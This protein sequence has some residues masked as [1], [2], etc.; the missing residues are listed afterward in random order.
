MLELANEIAEQVAKW[1]VEN[2]VECDGY[3]KK[4]SSFKAKGKI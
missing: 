3:K 2:D 4:A 1:A